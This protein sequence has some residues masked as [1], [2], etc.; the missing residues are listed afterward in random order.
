MKNLLIIRH[1][2]SSWDDPDLE[3]KERPLDN[4]G[5]G[6]ATLMA[7]VL[8]NHNVR[9]DKI[10][11][12]TALRAKMTLELIN[13]TLNFDLQ[14]IVYTDELYNASRRNILNFLKVLD[15]DLINVAIV[16]HN[17]GL[18][19]LADFLLYD[20]YYQLPTCAMV[21]IEL[22]INK[23]SDLKSGTGTLRFYEYPKKYKS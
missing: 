13:K 6:D 14:K 17:P 7:N 16:G 3:D 8:K 4:K 18:T 23:W 1:A 12:S 21:F 20:F 11:C 2:K 22:D 5:L 9:L 19:D 15:D 10:F